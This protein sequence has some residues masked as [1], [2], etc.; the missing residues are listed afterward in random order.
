MM[1]TRLIIL[2]ALTAPCAR[3]F[4]LPHALGRAP[5][6]L[7]AKVSKGK[8]LA[9]SSQADMLRQF[10]EA[11][12][13]A[14][15][16]KNLDVAKD[17]GAP[18]PLP[19]P[20]PGTTAQQQLPQQQ[21]LES[22]E[23]NPS[24]RKSQ[25][26]TAAAQAQESAYQNFNELVEATP[27]TLQDKFSAFEESS[28]PP[29][30]DAEAAGPLYASAP[31]GASVQYLKVGQPAPLE[32][33]TALRDPAGDFVP[34]FASVREAAGNK[35]L[36]LVCTH[37]REASAKLKVALEAIDKQLPRKSFKA[38]LVVVTRDSCA[39]NGRLAKAT[40]FPATV[41]S[42]EGLAGSAWAQSYGVTSQLSEFGV[43]VFA[44]D[45]ARQDLFAVAYDVEPL[46]VA[47]L[48][49]KI[50]AAHAKRFPDRYV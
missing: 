24:W 48:L 42:A 34:A 6:P 9:G 33:W 39:A 13:Q 11:K 17:L 43:S 2:L 1:S 25:K 36:V 29:R 22:L 4:L 19:P 40:G 45:T 21:P 49:K 28:P 46:A 20:P 3:S 14:Q 7:F 16:Q 35:P 37:H 5:S 18:A 41:L 10:E 15:Q 32:V 38:S 44:V 30:Y 27:R 50:V 12:L 23:A 8:K 47:E 26:A 31:L